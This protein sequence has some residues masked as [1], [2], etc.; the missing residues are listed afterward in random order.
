MVARHTDSSANHECLAV[1]GAGDAGSRW[2]GECSMVALLHSDRGK[3]T[4]LHS[5]APVAAR[6]DP[7]DGRAASNSIHLGR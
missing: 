6:A 7:P 5:R 4:I 3:A 1:A 2:P